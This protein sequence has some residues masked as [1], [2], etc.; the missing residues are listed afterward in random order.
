MSKQ[1]MLNFGVASAAST[2]SNSKRAILAATAQETINLTTT[3]LRLRPDAPPTGYICLPDRYTP[4]SSKFFPN[5]R[6]RVRVVDGDTYDVAIH[7]SKTRGT[8]NGDT[9]PVCVLNMANAY[10]AG[11]GWL[12]GATAQEEALCYRSTLYATLRKKYYPLKMREAIYSPTVVIFRENYKKNNQIMDFQQ[13]SNF[14]VVSVVSVA[15]IRDPAVNTH[16]SPPTYEDPDDRMWMKEKMRVTLRVAVHNKHRSVVLGALGCGA[17]RN[18]NEEVANCWVE[19]LQEQEF[20][21]W[22]NNLVF[23]VMQD[24]NQSPDNFTVFHDI[25]HGLRV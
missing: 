9:K 5:L 15:A 13:P 18:P 19:V 2:A 23:A 25:L 3:V 1:T 16:T 10:V 20:R 17:F 14:P 11:G 22:F 12:R 7:L 4:L 21:G 8:D 24:K 6:T